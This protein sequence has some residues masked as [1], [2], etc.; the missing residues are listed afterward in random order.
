MPLLTLC[1]SARPFANLARRSPVTRR[2]LAAALCVSAL[3]GVTQAQVAH[4]EPPDLTG[5]AVG[6]VAVGLNTVRG[7]ITANIGVGGLIFG[8]FDDTHSFIIPSGLRASS[9]QLVIS[10]YT[11][12]FAISGG[13]IV[14]PNGF[15]S[16][17]ETTGNGTFNIA[18]VLTPG[19]YAVHVTA[20]NF[21]DSGGNISYTHETRINVELNNDACAEPAT[22]GLGNTSFSNLT[23]TTDGPDHPTQCNFFGNAGISRDVWFSFTA[24]ASG[25]VTAQTCVST[26]DTELA[27]YADTNCA[28]LTSTLI[29]CNDDTSGCGSATTSS[30]VQW[31]ANAGQ[32]YL[33]RVGGFNGAG[34]TGNLSLSQ[35][36]SGACCNPQTGSCL[37]TLESTCT[38]LGLSFVG[39]GTTCSPANC[40]PCPADDDGDGDVDVVDLFNYLDAWFASQGVACP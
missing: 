26:F 3:S 9:V 5:Q 31:V 2:T 15:F 35:F 24:P 18:G 4:Q 30:V 13:F 10:N 37:A 14:G 11:Q 21:D 7:Q 29:G 40:T 19:T 1:W 28:T 25:L 27:V 8:D 20:N 12:V 33:I 6:T 16:S 32:T 23:A 38:G 36:T 34:G 39:W 22:I 17:F